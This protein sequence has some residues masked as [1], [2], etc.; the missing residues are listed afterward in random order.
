MSSTDSPESPGERDARSPAAACRVAVVDDH[1]FVAVAIESF[2][3]RLRGFEFAG[4]APS[5]GEFSASAIAADIVILDLRLGDGSS[6]VENVARVSA[7]GA[8]VIAF[9]AGD[10]PFLLRAVASTA[11]WG[12]IRKSASMSE[13]EDALRVVASG[14]PHMSTEW[15]AAV[16]SDP[17]LA[18]AG[19]SA[20]ERQ[21]LALFANGNKAQAVAAEA[22]I[23]LGTVDDYVRR[24]RAKYARAGRPAFTKIDLYK[25][26]LED[27]F[28]PL[29]ERLLKDSA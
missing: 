20:K 25:R 1:A 12:I 18:S 7:T 21:V 13:L 2:V 6:P 8:R 10:N 15:A 16:D 22:F 28:L 14:R 26:A 19:L 3:E 27:G 5:V 24:I 17:A 23:A 29:P 4:S 9:S 11:L